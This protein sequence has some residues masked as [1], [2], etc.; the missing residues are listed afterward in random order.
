MEHILQIK[1][2]GIDETR[3]PIVRK[4]PY[5]DLNFRLSEEPPADW[6]DDFRRLT[7]KMA[8]A[9]HFNA[10]SGGFIETYVR[11]MA[12]IPV[13]LETLKAKIAECNALHAE[14]LAELTRTQSARSNKLHDEG[15]AQ[16]RLNKIIEKLDFD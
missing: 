10:K 6:L 12:E 1:V 16:G 7:A 5:I 2:T 15:G 9:M 4:E 3:P 11:D 13:A 14:R 8:P